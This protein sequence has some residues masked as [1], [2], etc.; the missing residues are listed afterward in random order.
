[1]E[2]LYLGNLGGSCYWSCRSRMHMRTIQYLWQESVTNIGRDWSII[3][4]SFSTEGY[5]LK[6]SHWPSHLGLPSL[7]TWVFGANLPACLELRG[8][9]HLQCGLWGS[10]HSH[11]AG[12]GRW[13]GEWHG[14]SW[15]SRLCGSEHGPA[16]DLPC[17][18]C[19]RR[20]SWCRTGGWARHK[21]KQTS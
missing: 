8:Q 16:L 21:E 13:I 19:P 10:A 15:G 20:R 4:W 7:L 14:C 17:S 9:S 18:V 6:S 11:H 1:M 12:I 5:F 2:Q 3:I